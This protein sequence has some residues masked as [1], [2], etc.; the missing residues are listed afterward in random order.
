MF[1]GFDLF[2]SWFWLVKQF[3]FFLAI[4]VK[5]HGKKRSISSCVSTIDIMTSA[6]SLVKWWSQII[7]SLLESFRV[8]VSI[9]KKTTS[10]TKLEFN[11]VAKIIAIVVKRLMEN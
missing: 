10:C 9:V 11:L 7:A 6:T 3:F 1:V 8:E 5:S 2:W 4:G